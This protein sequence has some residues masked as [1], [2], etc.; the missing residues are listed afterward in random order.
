V[1]AG[2]VG[3]YAEIVE[4]SNVLWLAS[5]NLFVKNFGL[6]K[7][8]RSMVFDGHLKCLLDRW[9]G[10]R[11]IGS[12]EFGV[13]F[14]ESAD[15]CLPLRNY[16]SPVILRASPR[17]LYAS[18]LLGWRAIAWRIISTAM[19]FCPAQDPQIVQ[20]SDMLWLLGQNLPI[21]ILRLRKLTRLLVL[22]GNLKGL[23]DSQL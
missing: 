19:S 9:L 1:P 13:D 21:E 17:L 20:R 22:P 5:Q 16:V 8:T 11:C 23:F 15:G 18:A 14:I 3:D 6:R 7:L 4:R 10:H 12:K 2:L